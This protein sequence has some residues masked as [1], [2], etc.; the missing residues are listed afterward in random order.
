M[1]KIILDCGSHKGESVK[2][3]K[4]L[5][6]DFNDYKVYMFEPNTNLFK[7]ISLNPEFDSCI[8]FQKAVSDKNELVKFYGGTIRTDN[9]DSTILLDKKNYDSYS[10]DDYELV[11]TVDISQFIRDNFSKEDYIILKLDVEGAE[12]QIIEKLLNDDT[13]TYINKLYMEWHTEWLPMYKEIQINLEH[14]MQAINIIYE[15]WD[16]LN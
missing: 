10:E 16:A 13:F 12:Y 9:C 1:R 4:T 5:I 11:E 7:I 8:K 2:K 15:Y 14:R 3:F 6:S